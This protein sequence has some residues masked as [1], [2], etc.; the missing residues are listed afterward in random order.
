MPKID[1]K[2]KNLIDIYG[3]CINHKSTLLFL[4]HTDTSY[5]DCLFIAITYSGAGTWNNTIQIWRTT[6]NIQVAFAVEYVTE[7]T[8]GNSALPA[9]FNSVFPLESVPNFTDLD[10]KHW[11]INRRNKIVRKLFNDYR[12]LGWFTSV[13]NNSFNKICL[14]DKQ[15]NSERIKLSGNTDRA[16]KLYCKV[17]PQKLK[18]FLPQSIHD[19]TLKEINKHSTFPTDREGTYKKIKRYV[20]AWINDY[21]EKGMSINEAKHEMICLRTQLII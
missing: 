2:L 11:N 7:T 17:S 14:F 12:I 16:D 5:R 8:I 21:V 15:P 4:G 9:I 19:I 10:I 20:N 3:Y 13:E 18:F 6:T 1:C